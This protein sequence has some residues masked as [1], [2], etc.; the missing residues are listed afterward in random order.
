M[1]KKRKEI[2]EC[3][4]VQCSEQGNE[5][6][7]ESRGG[8]NEFGIHGRKSKVPS[9]PNGVRSVRTGGALCTLQLNERGTEENKNCSEDTRH[10]KKED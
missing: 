6:D 10:G 3:S 8:H 1:K 4:R 7:Q 5:D 2:L 9:L